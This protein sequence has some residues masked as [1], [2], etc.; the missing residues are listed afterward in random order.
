MA[1]GLGERFIETWIFE[2]SQSSSLQYKRGSPH[3][4]GVGGRL[5]FEPPGQY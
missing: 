2:R 4:N 5:L 1:K 3:Y